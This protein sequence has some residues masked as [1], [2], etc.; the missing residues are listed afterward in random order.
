MWTIARRWVTNWIEWRLATARLRHGGQ[1]PAE[2][3]VPVR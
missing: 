2:P 1:K 3:G